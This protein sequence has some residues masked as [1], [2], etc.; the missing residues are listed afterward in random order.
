M[1]VMRLY[2]SM[3]EVCEMFGVTRATISRWE[4]PKTGCGFPQRVYLGLRKPVSYAT[5]LGKRITKRSNC[6]IGY[7]IAE[8]DAYNELRMGE[9]LPPPKG[10]VD[11]HS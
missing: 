5:G 2:Y 10:A 3:K 11:K 1:C 8:V 4:H 9:R 6:R 7:P